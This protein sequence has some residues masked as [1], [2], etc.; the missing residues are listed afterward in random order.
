MVLSKNHQEEDKQS[1]LLMYR[2]DV[3][4]DGQYTPY[5]KENIIYGLGNPPVRNGLTTKKIFSRKAQL[6]HEGKMDEQR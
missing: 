4:K 2:T 5:G 1:Q 6:I 3:E